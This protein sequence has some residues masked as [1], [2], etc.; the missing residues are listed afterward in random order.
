MPEN[1]GENLKKWKERYDDSIHLMLDF[2]DFKGRQVE[3]LGL[4]LDKLK[5]NSELHIPMVR[6]RFGKSVWKDLEFPLNS[7]WFMRFKRLEL[8]DVSEGVFSLPS[9][10]DKKYAQTMSE[11][12]ILI[13]GGFLRPS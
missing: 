4:P 6:A 2:S 3:V 10:S 11:M 7:F 13:E 12:Q 8:F 5:W 9:K 1:V